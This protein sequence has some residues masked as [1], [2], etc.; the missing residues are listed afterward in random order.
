MP[1]RPTQTSETNRWIRKNAH[2]L[3]DDQAPMVQSLRALAATMDHE[4]NTGAIKAATASAYRAAF[5]TLL[6]LRPNS[7]RLADQLN[8]EDDSLMT[9][10]EWQA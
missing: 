9:P 10:T 1:R 6:E 5:V 4:L 7:Q 2:W 3:S 8:R